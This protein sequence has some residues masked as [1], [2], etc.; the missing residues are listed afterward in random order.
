VN[1]GLRY[2]RMRANSP[3]L[4]AVNTRLQDAG[5]TIAGL[6]DMFTWNTWAPR[7]GFN[8]RLTD[9]GKTIMRGTYGRSYQPIFLNDFYNLHPGIAPSTL[10]RWN[11]ATSSYSTIISVTDSRANLAFDPD[12]EPSLADLYSIGVDRELVPN[13]GVA[14]TYVHKR[15]EKQIGWKDIGGVYGTRDE[16]LPDGRSIAVYPL[17]NATSVHVFEGRRIDDDR[18][19]SERRHQQRRAAGARSST[20]VPVDRWI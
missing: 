18:A 15:G 6:G 7:T 3:D 8:L 16:I 14:V 11:P 9:D 20:F 13:L 1:V 4:P 10:A 2:D 19:G 12:V 17:L 5:G